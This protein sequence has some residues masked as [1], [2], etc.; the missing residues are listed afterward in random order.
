M[1]N[2]ANRYPNALLF[3]PNEGQFEDSTRFIAHTQGQTFYFTQS[4]IVT[5]FHA[6]AQNQT[7][8]QAN[9]TALF[10][11]FEGAAP[12]TPEGL[13]Q[14]E[15]QFHYFLG[16]DT[17]KWRTHLPGYQT[18]RYQNLY[19]GVDLILSGSEY[20]LKFLWSLRKAG[21]VGAIRIRYE[22]AEEIR[23]SEDGNLIIRH[24]LGELIDPAPVAWQ[25]IDE[26]NVP[27]VCAYA[28]DGDTVSF[29]L[30]G[31][32]DLD[33]PLF[34]DPILPYSTYL[35]GSG[36]DYSFAV[37]ADSQGC[38]YVGGYSLS[39]S[40]PTTPGAYQTTFTG[41]AAAI[42]TK[43][44]A[45]GKTLLYSTFLGG[46][47]DHT[48]CM[49][50]AVDSAFCA[51]LTGYTRSGGFPVTPGAV[52][53]VPGGDTDA[54]VTKLS[55]DGASLLYSTYLG[56]NTADYGY[57]IAVDRQGFAYVAGYTNSDNFPVTLG[58][59]QTVRKG[60]SDAFV[61]KLSQNG[62][63][64]VYSTYFGGTVATY[65]QDIAVDK[66]GCAYMT[67]SVGSA[68][69]PVTPG[70]FQPSSGGGYD[71]FVTK[72]SADG[73]NLVYSSYLGG[74]SV[75]NGYSIAV[76]GAG[77]AVVAG[78]TNSNNFPVTP[79][80]FQ[81]VYSGGD[82]D[83]FI[84][85]V[86]QNGGSL[87]GSTYLGGSSGDLAYRTAVDKKSNVYITGSTESVDFPITPQVVPSSL[88]GWTDAFVSIL[89]P[90]LS[91]LLVSFYLGGTRSNVGAG[92]ALGENGAVYV[93]GFTSSLD[94]PV[95]PGGFQTVFAGNTDAFVVKEGFVLLKKASIALQG[96]Q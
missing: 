21:N 46:S 76:D 13:Y 31:A 34:I 90:D 17:A 66:Q 41:T 22:G 93:S 69:L 72:F 25:E 5:A 89:S 53:T 6:R 48:A 18:L 4:G 60:F 23:I 15:G 50:I 51:Y 30:Y 33:A 81:T 9:A 47:A 70:V 59:Y 29:I 61:S 91:R 35:G 37:A 95:T 14:A 39:L 27:V 12:V 43:F 24:A 96:L 58:A 28:V 67:G 77:C 87:I 85:K 64:L 80:A 62:T 74:S 52:Q 78:I 83:V 63:S 32:Y 88:H 26:K 54:F 56:G 79:S 71:A 49:S 86:S 55:A 8:D 36:Y 38:A 92:I 68:N 44:S 10:L 19:E 94:F 75:D 7:A 40:F 84:S 57:G 20:S 65:A 2:T 45:D 16:N 73:T 1:I 3:I 11:S 42:L 82:H